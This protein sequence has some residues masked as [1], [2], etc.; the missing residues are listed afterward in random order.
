MNLAT[1]GL[2]LLDLALLPASTVCENDGSSSAVAPRRVVRT[3]DNRNRL[4]SLTFPDGNGNQTWA[5]TPDSKPHQVITQDVASSTQTINTYTYNKRRLL[6]AETAGQVNGYSWALGYAYDTNGTLSGIQYP[7][8]LYVDYAPNALGQATRAGSY[9]TGISYHPNGGM[10][11]FVY[12]NGIAHTTQ[13]NGRQLPTR[14]KAG[15]V[16]DNTYS[17][18]ANGNVAQIADALD[19]TRARTMIYDGLDRLAQ[20]TSGS[21]G[22]GGQVTYSYDALDNLRTTKLAGVKEY[23][24]WYDAANRLSN[25]VDDAGATIIGLAYDVQGNLAN[26]NGQAFQFD[27]GNRLRSAVGKE[28]YSYDGHGRRVVSSNPS[29]GNIISMYGQ[30]GVLRRQDNDREAKSVEYVYLNGSLIAKVSTTTAPAAP[31][32]TVPAYSDTGSYTVSWNAAASATTYEL[33]EQFDGGAWQVSY[34][35]SALSIA[36]SGKS[37]GL[38][39]YRARAC[40]GAICG[41]W[42]ATASISVQSIPSEISVVSAPSLSNNGSYTVSWTGTSGAT[43]YKLDESASGGSW[44]QVQSTSALFKSVTGKANGTYSYRVS[45]C[46]AAGC[47]GVSGSANVRVV[48]PP[49]PAP[50]LSAPASSS[51][52]SYSVSWAAVPTTTKYHLEESLPG[53]GWS[54]IYSG[55]GSSFAIGGKGNGTYLYR[56]IA[57]NDGGC[58]D[59]S[60]NL[61]VSVLLPPA[62]VPVLSVPA[63]NSNGSYSA[64]WTSVT[65]ATTYRLEESVNG[66]AWVLIYADGAI[67]RALSEKASA[68]YSYRVQACNTSGCGSWS[69]AASVSVQRIPNVPAGNYGTLESPSKTQWRI[70]AFWGVVPDATRYELK[71]YMTYNGTATTTSKLIKSVN[72]PEEALSF[73]VRACNANG[74]SAW[75]AIFNAY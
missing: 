11:Q 60:Q 65:T 1:P 9:A 56:A 24:Y 39:G 2:D 29:Q 3:Y 62:G 25:I 15:T 31:T 46:N 28:S 5:Y 75:S 23:N 72:P 30:D 8:G 57:C 54:E 38:Y 74:C 50:V 22:G 10:S 73:Q 53:G 21:F 58:S 69:T 64:S 33:Q 47:G 44:S 55:S 49:A 4:T 48:H 34:N 14:V 63:T 61:A 16:L 43:S 7:S 18:D 59:Y 51:N 19:S 40:R 26:K 67:N 35:G 32:V 20:A 42:G 27:F 45:A 37:G 71:G 68:T 66:G 41:A 36:M 6:T 13:Q 52:G 12:G 70:S 17:Y